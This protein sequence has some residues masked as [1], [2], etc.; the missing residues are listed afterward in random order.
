MKDFELLAQQWEDAI[1][2][3]EDT[4]LIVGGDSVCGMN[5]NNCQCNGNNCI[6]YGGTDNCNCNSQSTGNN[7]QCV[8]ERTSE[9]YP[10]NPNP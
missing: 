5:G 2:T 10:F 1:L 7:C 6:C 8:E 3:T 4:L 9:I